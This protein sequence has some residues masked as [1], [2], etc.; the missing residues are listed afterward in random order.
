MYDP[1][2]RWALIGFKPPC[3]VQENSEWSRQ[4]LTIWLG[5]GACVF[6]TGFY[7]TRI[8]EASEP[9]RELIPRFMLAES[10]GPF[11]NEPPVKDGST[12]SQSFFGCD[13]LSQALVVGLKIA[14]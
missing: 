3:L 13:K 10:H 9:V 1:S 5:L 12:V 8:G 11:A 4:S 7:R 2:A 6:I 14:R